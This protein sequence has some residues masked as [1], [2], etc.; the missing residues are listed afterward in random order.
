MKLQYTPYIEDIS[1]AVAQQLRRSSAECDAVALFS[2]RGGR[3]FFGLGVQKHPYAEIPEIDRERRL[4]RSILE[5]P[6]CHCI[7]PSFGT[8]ALRG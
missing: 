1:D 7:R 5:L 3:I 6:A 2:N 8:P 4:L